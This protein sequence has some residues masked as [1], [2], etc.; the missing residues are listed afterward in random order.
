MSQDNENQPRTKVSD[1][2]EQHELEESSERPTATFTQT[3]DYSGPLDE[4]KNSDIPLALPSAN[5]SN[6]LDTL[7]SMAKVQIS[8]T[9]TASP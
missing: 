7:S 1:H 8:S 9:S 6:L 2:Y 4:E 5:L 3:G